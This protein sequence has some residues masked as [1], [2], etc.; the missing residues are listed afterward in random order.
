MCKHIHNV[1][2]KTPDLVPRTL[3]LMLPHLTIQ[4]AEQRR[5]VLL[6]YSNH[7]I[8]T[9][10]FGPCNGKVKSDICHVTL[11]VKKDGYTIAALAALSTAGE[12][13]RATMELRGKLGSA[14]E[15]RRNSAIDSFL[16]TDKSKTNAW[17]NNN[18]TM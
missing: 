4:E 17:E 6:K 5:S 3:P 15:E 1:K 7:E 13:T 12:V 2:W 14:I 10:H 9:K 8:N 16:L 18:T 11:N